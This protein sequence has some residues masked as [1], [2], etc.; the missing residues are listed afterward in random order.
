VIFHQGDPGGSL[1]I[2]NS[3]RVKIV[4]LS[5]EGQELLVAIL[6]EGDLLGELAL[7][8]GHPRTATAV[9]VGDTSTYTLDQ[10]GFTDFLAGHPQSTIAV[11]QS[12]ARRLREADERLA[13]SAFLSLSQRLGRQLLQLAGSHG[14]EAAE[15]TVLDLPLSQRELAGLVGASRQSVNKLLS[16]WEQDGILRR[17]RRSITLVKPDSF[18]EAVL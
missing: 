18:R 11:A 4:I 7:L 5:E 1:H 2:I 15:G 8:D 6:G 3:G 13:E 14:R 16:Q 9:A 17:R 12:L 10:R